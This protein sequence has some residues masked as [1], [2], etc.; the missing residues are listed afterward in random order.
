MEDRRLEL[1]DLSEDLGESENRYRDR[2]E[3][4]DDLLAELRAW[5]KSV[6]A[7]FPTPNPNYDFIGKNARHR[8]R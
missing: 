4:A 3:L 2:P 5:Q 1:Y 8:S 6:G 7:P